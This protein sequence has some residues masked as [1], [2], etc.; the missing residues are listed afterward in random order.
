MVDHRRDPERQYCLILEWPP[1]DRARW[2]RRLGAGQHL[3]DGDG[4]LAASWR[5][6]TRARRA[7]AFG[8][9]TAPSME[10]H[11]RNPDTGRTGRPASIRPSLLAFL[12]RSPDAGQ[13]RTSVLT[14]LLATEAMLRAM[15]PERDWSWLRPLLRRLASQGSR[16]ARGQSAAVRRACIYR[17]GLAVMQ[18]ST[19]AAE[20]LPSCSA[21]A[22]QRYR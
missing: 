7:H 11:G 5:R 6:A 8:S 4:G 15:H 21:R 20:H 9:P 10:R 14:L 3:L 13:P 2:S 19:E 17:A 18:R 1:A 22:P 12:E 16:P